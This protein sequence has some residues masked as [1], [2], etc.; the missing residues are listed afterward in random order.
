MWDNA[1]LINP[2][3]AVKYK[4]NDGDVLE[5]TYKGRKLRVPALRLPGHAQGSITLHLG[6]GRTFPGRVAEGAGVNAYALRTS[7]APWQSLGLNFK[8]TGA[9]YLLASVQMHHNMAGRDLVRIGTLSEF[10]ENPKFAEKPEQEAG[11]GPPP[12]ELTIYQ[13]PEPMERRDK[14]EGNRWGM[15]INLNT[16]IGCAACVVACQ[17]ENNFPVVGKTQVLAGREMHWL[18]IDR[19]YQS[20][21]DEKTTFRPEP[22]ANNPRTFFQPVTCMHCENAPCEL[23]C[24]VGATT[25]SAE[26]I[27][28]MTYNRCVGTRY[29]SN[30]CP[31]KVRRFNFL[32]YADIQNPLLKMAQNPDVTVR[33]RGV[34]EK[35]TYC[36][37]RVN[38]ARIASEIRREERVPGNA[39]RTACQ[40]ACPTR[41]ITFGNL[42][43][44]EAEV[45]KAKASPRNYALLAETNARPRT[46]YL[47]RLTNPNEVL[48]PPPE[49]EAHSSETGEPSEPESHNE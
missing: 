22:A 45:V 47:A 15:S 48:S 16:C 30:N 23:V 7:D 27:N 32:H 19:Y 39:V 12:P 43:D 38:N 6:H 17:A 4:I 35:C 5:L 44:P 21:Q 41:A 28:E 24:P 18:R 37:Q 26:G 2:V 8:P 42:N 3:D 31:Y 34:M 13:H 1:A 46:T 10:K 11:H 20:D 36:I 25:H 49:P 40:G 29:C 33:F 14:G 9:T